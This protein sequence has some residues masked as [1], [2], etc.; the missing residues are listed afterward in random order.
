M[1]K[2]KEDIDG[3]LPYF[4]H[5]VLFFPSFFYFTSTIANTELF[6]D[7]IN[8]IIDKAAVHAV[9]MH[10]ALHTVWYVWNGTTF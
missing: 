8:L 10:S 2:Y 7:I 5:T 9:W 4:G 3:I 1:I 6:N